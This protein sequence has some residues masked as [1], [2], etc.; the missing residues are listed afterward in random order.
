MINQSK[1]AYPIF[2]GD[3]SLSQFSAWLKDQNDFSN[4]VLLADENTLRHCVPDLISGIKELEGVEFLEIES[5]EHQKNIEVATQLW[6]AL[7]EMHLDRN[8]L[9]I[10]VGGGVIGDIGGFVAAAYKR[11]VSF[12]QIPTTLLAMVDASVG[13]KVGIDLQE[14]KNQVG[15]FAEPKAVVVYPPFLDTLHVDQVK[16]GYAEM[17]KHGLIADANYYHELQ[18]FD[19]VGCHKFIEQS[20]EIKAAI[21]SLDFTEQ[22]KRKNLNFG[23]TFGHAFESLYLNS[24]EPILHGMAIVAGMICEVLVSEVLLKLPKNVAED[25]IQFL[26]AHY[27]KIPFTQEDFPAI[28]SLMKNDKKNNN[29]EIKLVGIT[30]I[31]KA[32]HDISIEDEQVYDVLHQYIGLYL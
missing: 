13:G 19:L 14:L 31:G 5:G 26:T 24:N 22:G 17:I 27:Q 6:M 11:G 29:Q 15:F 10:N 20:I 16:S 21:V 1:L 30:E 23:H 28:L 25:I 12:V 2:F 8:S 7:S 18:E 3:N 4:I 9:I 32:V